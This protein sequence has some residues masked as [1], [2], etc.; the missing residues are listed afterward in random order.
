LNAIAADPKS[1]SKSVAEKCLTFIRGVYNMAVDDDLLE[2]EDSLVAG[3]ESW[4]AAL[5][6]RIN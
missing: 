2:N 5:R 4:D 1:Q 6:G 3:V